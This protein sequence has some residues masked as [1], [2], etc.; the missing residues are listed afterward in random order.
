MLTAGGELPEIKET[1]EV[2]SDVQKVWDFFQDVPQVADCMPGVELLGQKEEDTYEGRMKVKVGP[3]SANFQGQAKITEQDDAAR[4]GRISAKGADRQGGSRASATVTY[5]LQPSGTGTQVSVVA[6]VKLQGAMAQFGRTGLIQEVSSQ[7][8][9]TFASCLAG[10]LAATTPEE[11][12]EV[13]SA[14]VKGLSLFFRSLWR[15]IKSLFRRK[16]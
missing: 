13:R 4:T 12:A 9:K 14:H 15:W 8:T 11:A 5:E 6:D 7:L 3:I 1:F 2:A 16:R 10:K